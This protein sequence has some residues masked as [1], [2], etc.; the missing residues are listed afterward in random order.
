MLLFISAGMLSPKKQDSLIARKHIYLN[1]GVVGLATI[2][3]EAGHN[4]KIV[5]ANFIPPE[6]FF[7]DLHQKSYL[8]GD[9][10]LLL[11]IISAFSLEWSK[12]FLQK[13]QTLLS[14]QENYSWREMG[15]GY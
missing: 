4:P 8:E 11:S 10:P 15:S 3:K 2:L 13:S 14:Q 7:D 6:D 12:V 9:D 5:H 1:Y